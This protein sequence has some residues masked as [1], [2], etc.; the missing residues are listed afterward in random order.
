MKTTSNPLVSII[1][2]VYNGAEYLEQLIESVLEQDY[3]KIEH[4]IIDD[5]SDDGGATVA[6]LQK[7]THL[8]WWSRENRGQYPTMNEGM[9]AARGE[10]IC[11]IS[12]DDLVA[13]N[14]IS[15][16]VNALN[17]DP[18]LDGVYGKHQWI[19]ITGD[20][21]RYQPTITH[22]PLAFFCYLTFIAHCSLYVKVSF[23]ESNKI[24]F[25]ESLKYIGDYDWV[26]NMI[27]AGSKF[28]YEDGLFSSI[29]SHLGQTS[30]RF[31]SEIR[32]ER[33]RV[34]RKHN[35]SVLGFGII[36]F[37]RYWLSAIKRLVLL[38]RDKRG[39]EALKLATDWITRA[40]L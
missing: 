19:S 27:A 10:I 9:D 4:L 12:A 29:R 34:F 23:L 7:Y 14:A 36:R 37:A 38:I 5:G 8:R 24:R 2:P 28:T 3:E 35:V 40:R 15:R 32:E 31:K 18:E 6:V 16:A 11:F 33:N 13:P 39:K 30:N 20:L 1:T 22:G 26:L 25:D 21:H 17:R